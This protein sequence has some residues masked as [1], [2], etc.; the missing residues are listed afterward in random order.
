MTSEAFAGSERPEHR[1]SPSLRA[2]RGARIPA[3]L[4][5]LFLAFGGSWNE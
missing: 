1:A 4:P 2:L 3:V 5:V